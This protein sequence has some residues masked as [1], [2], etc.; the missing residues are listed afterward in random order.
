MG[1]TQ[2]VL[3]VDGF[4]LRADSHD[5]EPRVL[6]IALGERAGL[7]RPRTVRDVIK[8]AISDGSLREDEHFRF[9]RPR[10]QNTGRGRPAT[11]YWLTEA[12][13]LKVIT[14]LNT[15]AAD[16]IVDDM[17]RVYRSALRQ[18]TPP[19]PPPSAPA[20]PE[21]LQ[22]LIAQ[23]K[24]VREDAEAEATLRGLITGVARVQQLTFQRVHGFLRREFRVVSCRY[25]TLAIAS[26]ARRK[27]ID[28][29]ALKTMVAPH[30]ALA[31]GVRRQLH[32]FEDEQ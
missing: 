4:E 15:P 1:S 27:L 22:D 29:I 23:S 14:R 9:C 21:G 10:R 28:C 8:K 16:A 6:D 2:I 13:A 32:L 7:A 12:G 3:H 19:P 30:L 20:I 31:A 18:L 24:T 25:M 5:D 11:E 26:L 17:I